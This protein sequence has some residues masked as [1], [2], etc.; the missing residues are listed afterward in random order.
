MEMF[1]DIENHIPQIPVRRNVGRVV[2]DG[3]TLFHKKD[4]DQ[5][6]KTLKIKASVL[7]GRFRQI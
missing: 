6:Q 4:Q 7:G 3:S 2:A 1:V 5:S